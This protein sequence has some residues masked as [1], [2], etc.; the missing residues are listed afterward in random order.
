LNCANPAPPYSDWSAA[1]TSIQDAIGAADPGDLILVTNGVYQ[2]GAT[3]VYG[4]SN[5]VA[6]IKPV[7]VQSVN[8]PGVTLIQASN[9]VGQ[10]G[11]TTFTDTTANGPGPFFY[12]VGVQ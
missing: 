3:L 7:M 8:G 2:T 4:T 10:T 1:A 5:R 11:A 12:R 6:V 9:L